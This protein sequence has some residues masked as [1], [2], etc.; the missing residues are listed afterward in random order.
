MTMGLF[1]SGPSNADIDAFVAAQFEKHLGTPQAV[2]NFAPHYEAMLH[3]ARA[4]VDE[5]SLSTWKR[6]RVT[7]DI[8]GS[9]RSQLPGNV[10]PDLMKKAYRIIS[11]L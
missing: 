1:S 9:L 3:E 10:V 7:G 8:E 2:A 11:D 5:H 4:W 6:A